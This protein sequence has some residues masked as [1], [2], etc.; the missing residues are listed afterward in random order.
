VGANI[1]ISSYFQSK[2]CKKIIIYFL[3]F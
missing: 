2:F 3:Y 1:S